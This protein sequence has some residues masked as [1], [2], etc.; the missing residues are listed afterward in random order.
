MK[1][2]LLLCLLA[3]SQFYFS[4]VAIGKT[5]ITNNSVS[6]EFGNISNTNIQ[7]GILLPWI[8]DQ[9]AVVKTPGTIIFD[10]TD[11][12]I[13]YFKGG[14]S[15]IWEDLTISNTGIVD[16][17]KQN[18]LDEN[19]DSKVSIGVP[20]NT[21]GVLVLEDTDKA[22]ILPLIDGYQTIK[23][24]SPGL[25]AYDTTNNLFCVFNGTEWTFWSAE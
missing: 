1:K 15:K 4:Q 22:M 25:I 19:E 20:T 5:N 3:F 18:T 9:E 17:S 10:A 12:K 23:N 7:K 24:P 13:K 14:E 8:T 6:L 16:V 21:P 11:R 2:G